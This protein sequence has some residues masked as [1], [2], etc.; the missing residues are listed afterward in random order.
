MESTDDLILPN[1]QTPLRYKLDYLAEMR[2]THRFHI[3]RS[4][5]H[6]H[7]RQVKND[8]STMKLI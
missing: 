2:L 4:Y 8:V 3:Y 6:R 7:T 5:G 1:K